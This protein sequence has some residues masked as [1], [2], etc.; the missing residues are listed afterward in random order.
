MKNSFTETKKSKTRSAFARATE[1][2]PGTPFDWWLFTIMLTIL[3]IG[4][5][6]V[7]SAS[8]IVAE[9]VNGDKYYFFKRQLLFAAGGGVALWGAALLPREWLYKLQYPALFFSLL[10]LLIT[11]SPFA[12]AINGAKRWIPLGPVSV[13]PMEFVKIALALYL[14]YFMSS[15]QELIKTFSRG[16]IPPFAVTGLFCFLLLLQPDFGSAVV[17]AGILFF[18]CVA[19]GTR[20]IYLFFSLALACAGAMALA[21]ASPYRLRRLLAFLDPFQDAHNTGY[22]LVQSLLPSARAAFSAWAWGPAN[23]RCSICPKRT[24]TSSWPCWPRKWALWA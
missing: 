17:L 7:L 24:T 4:L 1:K 3:A 14:A 16:V 10:L 6:M 5:V 23:R 9:Q 15:K 2:G 11:L 20:F 8:G 21:I 12:P 18:M 13:Q 22:Q 19:G